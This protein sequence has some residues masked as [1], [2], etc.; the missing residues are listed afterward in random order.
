M[1]RL[2]FLFTGILCAALLSGCNNNPCLVGNW[3]WTNTIFT[4]GSTVTFNGDGTGAI[5]INDC[6]NTCPQVSTDKTTRYNLNW[7]LVSDTVL[8][9]TVSNAGRKCGNNYLF[10]GS[11]IIDP[12]TGVIRCE[13]DVLTFYSNSNLGTMELT[14]N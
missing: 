4:C 8:T 11:E 5:V 1:K 10:S 7:S 3:T 9:V 14:R 13:G 2:A 6:A 12:A